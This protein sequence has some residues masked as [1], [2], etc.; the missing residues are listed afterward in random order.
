[1]TEPRLTGLKTC[2]GPS[3]LDDDGQRCAV[4]LPVIRFAADK[5]SKLDGLARHCRDCQR[6]YSARSRKKHR[7]RRQSRASTWPSVISEQMRGSR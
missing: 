1:M 6:I 7:Q 2:R 3:H 4:E 5:H